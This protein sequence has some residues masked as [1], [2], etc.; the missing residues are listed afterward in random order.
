VIYALIVVVLRL[1]RIRLV[2]GP[3]DVRAARWG[4]VAAAALL[5]SFLIIE[6]V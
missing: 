3:R 5:W 6:G 1:P 2:L 4:I